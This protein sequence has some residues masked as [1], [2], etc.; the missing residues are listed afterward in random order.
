MRR[1]VVTLGAV[2]TATA[3][4]VGPSAPSGAVAVRPSGRPASTVRRAAFM[5]HRRTP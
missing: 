5:R 1:F 3:A 2:V 4:L